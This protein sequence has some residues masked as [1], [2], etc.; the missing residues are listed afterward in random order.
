[1]NQICTQS[2]H[3]HFLSKT[4]LNMAF[5]FILLF[6]FTINYIEMLNYPC[7]LAGAKTA[8]YA[9]AISLFNIISIATR[10]VSLLLA[11]ML[12]KHI[13][14]SIGISTIDNII[15]DINLIITS[16]LI[17]SISCYLL[18]NNFFGKFEVGIKYLSKNS[19]LKMLLRIISYNFKSKKID[20]LPKSKLI[21]QKENTSLTFILSCICA[22]ALMYTGVLSALVAGFIAPEFRMTA[23]QLSGVVSGV[24]VLI[25]FLVCDPHIAK[26][27]DKSITDAKRLPETVRIIKAKALSQIIGILLAFALIKPGAELIAFIAKSL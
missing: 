25:L 18:M 26:L 3:L 11:P 20:N 17:G 23:V 16:S 1:M 21:T 4:K 19:P 9:T 8:N 7:K 10:V 13:E 5:Y 27:I 6:A 24:G 15:Y 14:S 12:S 2:A 22:H